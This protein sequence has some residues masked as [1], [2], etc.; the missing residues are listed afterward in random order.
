MGTN[1]TFCAYVRDLPRFTSA[2]VYREHYTELTRQVNAEGT[3]MTPEAMCAAI[4]VSHNTQ[5][6]KQ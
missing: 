1:D 3:E 2:Q 6:P 4:L 5:Q